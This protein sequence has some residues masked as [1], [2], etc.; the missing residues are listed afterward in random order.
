MAAV[1]ED[2]CIEHV[3]F[4]VHSISSNKQPNKYNFEISQVGDTFTW[5]NQFIFITRYSF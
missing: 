1:H 4:A 5:S 2:T 3:A